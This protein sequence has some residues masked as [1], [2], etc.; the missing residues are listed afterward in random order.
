[1]F[2]DETFELHRTDTGWSILD[3]M[4]N[5]VAHF[6]DKRQ[7]EAALKQIRANPKL[8]DH[9]KKLTAMGSTL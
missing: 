2:E 5:T 3:G 1:M 7:A 8:A 9:P 4:T 6:P